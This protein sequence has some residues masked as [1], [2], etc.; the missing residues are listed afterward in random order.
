VEI[1]V[2]FEEMHLGRAKA[3]LVEQCRCPAGYSG[4]SCQVQNPLILFVCLI[5]R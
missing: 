3:H 5:V 2:K 4:L 1:A